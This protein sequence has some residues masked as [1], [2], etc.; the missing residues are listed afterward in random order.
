MTPPAGEVQV[1]PPL[2]WAGGKRWQVPHLRP[3]W[4]PHRH[5]RL[6][7]PFCGGL[8]VALGLGPA[9]ALLNDA[10]PHLITFYVWLQ[11]GLRIEI[12]LANDEK[13]YY[14]HRRRFNELI[15]LGQADG[16]EAASLFYY[17]NR[18]GYNGLCRFN[19]RGEF[20]VP[21]GKYARIQ[22]ARD[23]TSYAPALEAWAFANDDLERLEVR[24]TFS[25]CGSAVR[26]G[27]HA[28]LASPVLVG[29]PGAH[30]A[31]R[32]APSRPGG[33]RQ[34]GHGPH[35]ALVPGPRL[36]RE[37]PAG[38][39]AHQLHRGSPAGA[40]GA[41]DSQPLEPFSLSCGERGAEFRPDCPDSC[42][43]PT[44]K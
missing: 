10:N 25:L 18:T 16:R 22:Y 11:R 27:V 4:A 3:L 35:R 37:V 44:R 17:L 7:E 13:V 24:R 33:A 6:V 21:F 30:G 36:R 5:R 2:K 39:P 20:N 26:R 8:A 32:R 19:S 43:G 12:E 9:R 34:S 23:L 42:H 31:L 15:R 1:R 41:R 29:G 40:R 38:A 14:A 28:V